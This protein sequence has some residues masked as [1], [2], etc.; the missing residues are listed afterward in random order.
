V[1]ALIAVPAWSFLVASITIRQIDDNVKERLRK[2]A[3]AN[4]VSM[5]EEARKALQNWVAQTKPR[6]GMGTR[7]RRRFAALGGVEL[8]IP[9]RSG[10]MRPLPDIFKDE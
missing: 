9:A 8:D 3:A 2:R 10:K 7:I 4:G 1:I 5:E 6:G